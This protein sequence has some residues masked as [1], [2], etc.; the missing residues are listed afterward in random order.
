MKSKV[1]KF[2]VALISTFL[3]FGGA[4]FTACG[5]AP[6]ATISVSSSD[7]VSEDYIEID[8]GSQ[9]I[10]AEVVATVEGV[11]SGR[12]SVNN[13]NQSIIQTK[14]NYDENSNST[15]IT[16]TAV[17]EGMASFLLRS[18]EGNG[19]KLINVYVYS[20]ILD[21]QQKQDEQGYSNQYVVKG[22][23]TK[24]DAD[25][26]LTFTSRPGGESNRKDVN[27]KL[28]TQDES[29]SLNGDVLSVS[30]DSS[31]TQVKLQATSVYKPEIYEEITLAVISP[32]PEV[33]L[34]FSRN[35]DSFSEP[36]E[37]GA[38]YNL[39]KNDDSQL[40]AVAYIKLNVDV[41]TGGEL[42]SLQINASVTGAD[43]NQSDRI[44]VTEFNRMVS[45]SSTQI[46]YQIKALANDKNLQPELLQVSF[47]AKYK[48]F[49]Y[50]KSSVEFNVNLVDVIDRIEVTSIGQT[51]TSGDVVDIYDNYN[52]DS[53][54]QFGRPFVIS[55]GPDTVTNENALFDIEFNATGINVADYIRIFDERGAEITIQREGDKWVAKSIANNS[56]IYIRTSENF[57]AETQI[58]CKF[59]SQQSP[60][61]NVE[62]G[63]VCHKS[64]N[65]NFSI[66][67]QQV[68]YLSTYGENT[69]LVNVTAPALVGI[70]KGLSLRYVEN[71]VFEISDFTF[72]SAA[73]NIS[74]YVSNLTENLSGASLS[75]AVVH[76][77]GFRASEDIVIETFVPMK[78][79]AVLHQGQS[80]SSISQVEYVF[81]E[82][83]ELDA[84]NSLNSLIMKYGSSV[85]LSFNSNSYSSISVGFRYDENASA[86]FITQENMQ[87]IL[88]KFSNAETDQ[89]RYVT[90]DYASN[91]LT[92]ASA[93]FKGYV[94][95]TFKGYNDLHGEIAAYRIFYLE[96]YTS[97]SRLA[98]NPTNLSLTA[99]DSIS[100]EEKY[101]SEASVSISYRAD[102]RE[103]TYA[104]VNS[105]KFRSIATNMD[106]VGQTFVNFG[107]YEIENILITNK[108]ISFDVSAKTTQGYQSYSDQIEISYEI[109]G[110]IYYATIDIYIENAERVEVVD[111]EN[112]TSDE[113]IYL[114]LFSKETTDR[115]FPILT[116][117]LPNDAHNKD[118][119][120]TFFA[121]AGTDVDLVK[122]NQLGVVSIKTNASKGGTGFI[123]VY[124][125]DSIRIYD[126]IEQ[127]VYY[128]E[129]GNGE[130]QH[131]TPL[132]Q[133]NNYYDQIASGYYYKKD[134][135]TQTKI[136]Y[137]DIIKKIEVV[138]ADGLSETTAIR[139][140]NENQLKA[141]EFNRHYTLMNS[142]ELSSWSSLHQ[143]GFTGSL[144]GA[145]ANVV[146]SN[147]T[148]PLFKN[149]A[150]EGKVS[151]LTLIGQ[152]TGGGMVADENAGEISN[153]TIMVDS[154]QSI[155]PSSV[156]GGIIRDEQTYLGGAVGYNTGKIINVN[157]EGVT[158][159]NSTN[160]YVGGIVG[161][162]S[163]TISNSKFEFYIFGTE[164]ST[165]T[166]T[167]SG[168]FA[169]GIVGYANGGTIQNTYAYNYN[170]KNTTEDNVPIK[171]STAGN[172]N[173]GA[174]V[175]YAGSKF[176]VT[177]S[178][179]MI[180][181][182]KTDDTVQGLKAY[183]N[184]TEI[185]A[186]LTDVYWGHGTNYQSNTSSNWINPGEEGFL[187]YVRGGEAH[188]KTL[189]QSASVSDLGEFQIANTEK[190][191]YIGDKQGVLYIHKLKDS[192]SLSDSELAELKDLNTISL[193]DLFGTNGANVVA[194][195]DNALV[196][197]V[198]GNTIVLNDIGEFNLTISSKQNYTISET[199][200]IKVL[201]V[202]ADFTIWHNN[203]QTSGFNVQER[204]SADVSFTVRSS[205][206]LRGQA[207]ALQLHAMQINMTLVDEGLNDQVELSTNGMQGQIFVKEGTKEAVSP[208]ANFKV[209]AD[210]KLNNA[211]TSFENFDYDKA[212]KDATSKT[213]SITPVLGANDIR[214]SASSLTVV[215]S[216]NSQLTVILSTDD[217]DDGLKLRIEKGSSGSLTETV[218]GDMHTYSFA[219]QDVLQVLVS[220]SNY[221]SADAY[222]TYTLTIS[223]AEN[224]RS[225]IMD[226]EKY[227]LFI[228]S[229]SGT[230]DKENS[231]VELILTSQPINHIDI[232]NYKPGTT[233]STNGVN[234]YQR[235]DEATSVISPGRSSIMNIYID[236][237]FAYYEY[238]TLT[239]QN[240][241]GA[242]LGITK[243]NSYD[244][245]NKQYTVDNSSDV[246]Q[247]DYGVRAGRESDGFFA[248]RLNAAGNI[249]DDTKFVLTVQFYDKNGDPIEDAMSTYELF[250][251]YLPEA[252]ITIDGEVSAV[253]A[254]GGNLQLKMLLKSDQ[255]LDSV[256]ALN[257]SGIT[258][259]APSAWSVQDNGNGT[260]TLTAALYAN[261]DA[262]IISD[263]GPINGEF[264]L[265]AQVSRV[266]NGITEIKRSYAYITI[267]DFKPATASVYGAKYDDT[268]QMQVVDANIGISK[269]VSFEYQFDPETYSYDHS[270]GDEITLVENLTKARKQFESDKYYGEATD[271]FTI[272]LDSDGKPIPVYQRLYIGDQKLNFSETS[273]GSKVWTWS[274][275]NFRLTYREESN[276]LSVLGLITTSVTNPTIITLRD[277][278]R[279][280]SISGQNVVYPIET[281]FA[282]QVTVFSDVDMPI[283]IE[284]ENDFLQV[285]QE[286]TAQNYILMDDIVLQNY[287]PISAANFKSLDGNGHTIHIQSFNTT[288][289][290]TLNLALF[291]DIPAESIMK[292][293]KVNYYNGGNLT[294]DTTSAGYQNINVAGFA[295]SNSGTITNCQVIAYQNDG[296]TVQNGEVG[297]IVNLVRG[298][299]PYYIGDTSITSNVAGFVLNNSG[300]ITN[301]KVGGDQIIVIGENIRDN[302][303]TYTNTQ[304]QNF[305]ISAQGE[306]A[307]FVLSNSGEIASSGAQNIQITNKASLSSS[308]TAGF[309]VSNSGEIR[310]SYVEGVRQN[311]EE[312]DA[313]LYH[314]QGSNISSKGIVAGF[315]VNNGINGVV[316]DGYSNILI[317]NDTEIKSRTSAGFVYKNEGLVQYS[318]SASFVEKADIL[319]LNFSGVD[320]NG[321]NLNSGKIELSYYINENYDQDDSSDVQERISNQATLVVIG[322]ASKE[323]AFY[324][325]TF[326]SSDSSEDGVWRRTDEGPR[327]VSEDTVTVSHRYYVAIAADEYSLPYAILQNELDSSAPKYDTA[328]GST[329]NP[330]LI[331]NANDFKQAM[332]DSTS[333]SIGSYFSDSEVF[334]AYRFTSDI[335]LSQLN[336]EHGEAEV[337]SIDKLFSGTIDG[338][339]FAINN[340]SIRSSNNSVGLFSQADRAVI[341]N[342]DLL[343][344]NVTASNSY[345]VGG[346]VGFVEDSIIFNVHMTQKT[347]DTSSTGIGVLGR[348]IAG[349]I[350]GAAFGDTKLNNLTVEDAI[351]QASYYDETQNASDRNMLYRAGFDPNSIRTSQRQN[352]NNFFSNN[353]ATGGVGQVSFAGGVV[354]YLDVYN[355]LEASYTSF[356]Y[357]S[358]I[359]GSSYPVKKLSA[360]GVID[361]RGEV[362]GGVFGFT[363]Y[364]TK[365][366]DVSTK[367][368]T[369]EESVASILSYNYFAGGVVGLANGQFYQIYSEHEESV[370]DEIENTTANYYLAGS[371]ETQ[372]GALDLFKF[373]GAQASGEYRYNPKY[374][375]G[376]MGVIGSGSIYVGYNK[377]N[378]I[379]YTTENSFAGGIAGGVVAGSN[380]YIETSDV[381]Q[382][383]IATTLFLQ[384]VY[385]IGDVY[386]YGTTFDEKGN[387]VQS[388]TSAFGG[389]F[390]SLKQNSKLLLSSV[391]AFN[392]YGVLDNPYYAQT[393]ENTSGATIYAIAGDVANDAAVAVTISSTAKTNAANESEGETDTTSVKSFGYMSSYKSGDIS[394]NV[395]PLPEGVE[396]RSD[397]IFVIRSVSSFSSQS[398]GYGETNGAFI[399]SKAWSSENWT[400]ALNTLYPE[401]NFINSVNYIYL[402]QYNVDLV[403]EKM[404]NSSIEVRVRGKVSPDANNDEYGMVDL[405]GKE[406]PIEG[407][408]GTIVGATSNEWFDGNANAQKA[409]NAYKRADGTTDSGYPGL[410]L[411]Q[412][413][414]SNPGTGLRVSN[415]NVVIASKAQGDTYPTTDT[416][417]KVTLTGGM[418]SNGT[419]N[420]AKIQGVKVYVQAPV[421]VA[422]SADS[423]GLLAPSASSTSFTNIE[424]NFN[425]VATAS[426]VPYITMGGSSEPNTNAA[427][428]DAE[429]DSKGVAN[430]GLLV[431][432][433]TQNSI[434]EAIRIQNIDIKH[435][436]LNDSY[437]MKA[438]VTGNAHVGL[439]V[440][441][442]TEPENSGSEQN[443]PQN[444]AGVM[445]RLRAP[446]G[447][448]DHK[449][450]DP[451]TTT[452]EV[453]NNNAIAS[454]DY[455]GYFGL[456][457]SQN[458]QVELE[459]D[460]GYTQTIKMVTSTGVTGYANIG[461]LI[462][463]ANLQDFVVNDYRTNASANNIAGIVS[464]EMVFNANGTRTINGGNVGLLFGS[465]DGSFDIEDLGASGIIQTTT[466]TGTGTGTNST[467]T[468]NGSNFGG[469]IGANKSN[470]KISNVDVALSAYKDKEANISAKGFDVDTEN[471]ILVADTFN[472]GGFIGS[473]AAPVTVEKPATGGNNT[474]NNS[475]ANKIAFNASSA[476]VNAGDLIGYNVGSITASMFNS[477]SLISINDAQ[478]ANVGGLIGENLSTATKFTS[479]NSAI[480]I[481]VTSNFFINSTNL[482]AGGMI[483]NQ[484]K[485][486]SSGHS[487]EYVV[488][489][490]AFKVSVDEKSTGT[491]TVG[492]MIGKIDDESKDS[493]FE[494]S[495][496]KN[497]GDAIYSYSGD[498]DTASQIAQY[499]FGGL[500]GSARVVEKEEKP[501]VNVSGNVIAFTN[502]NPRLASS[503]S[504][505]S[506]LIGNGGSATFGENNYYSSQLVLATSDEKKMID[507][508]YNTPTNQGYGETAATNADTILSKLGSSLTNNVEVGSKLKPISETENNGDG[509]TNGITYYAGIYP[510][511]ESSGT[512]QTQANEQSNAFAY[513]GDFVKSERAI[514][515][516]GKHSFVAGLV[517]ENNYP[518]EGAGSSNIDDIQNV[519]GV[520]DVLNGGIVYASMATG[521]LSVGGTALKNVGGLV[522][523]MNGGL[524]AESTSSVNIVYRAKQDGTASAVATTSTGFS[525]FDKVYSTGEVASYISA[526]LYAFTNGE[527]A[528]VRDSYTIS[529]VNLKDYTA[530]TVSGTTGVFGGASAYNNNVK[531]SNNWYDADATEV[532]ESGGAAIQYTNSTASNNTNKSTDK[533]LAYGDTSTSSTPI[534]G[535]KQDI[536]YNYGYPTRNFA[537]F[538]VSTTET[539]DGKTYHLIPNATKLSQIKDG[540]GLNYKLVRDIDLS[541]TSFTANDTSWNKV[542]NEAIF[543]GDGHTI[544]GVKA[545]LFSSA[546]T[547]KNLRV[548]NAV[549]TGNAVVASTLTGLAENVT[550][551]GTLTGKASEDDKL[552]AIGGLFASAGNTTTISNC[553]NYV[554]VDDDKKGRNIGGIVGYTGGVITNCYNYSPI[555]VNS[556]GSYVGGI[557]GSATRI[558]NS[559]NENT[560][561]NGYTEGGNGK[562]Y[563]GGIAGMTTPGGTVQNCYN[564]AMVKAGNKGINAEGGNDKIAYAAGIVASA[565]T[566][567]TVTGC[568]NEG[569]IEALGSTKEASIQAEKAKGETG[570]A[571]DAETIDSFASR[572][573]QYNN[574]GI[575]NEGIT[576]VQARAIVGNAVANSDTENEN[577]HTN[578]GTIFQNGLFGRAR[579]GSMQ[580]TELANFTGTDISGGID[581]THTNTEVVA[582]TDSLGGPLSIYLKS[583][584]TLTYGD[585]VSKTQTAYTE[586][587]EFGTNT[588]N[589]AENKTYE[590]RALTLEG[591]YGAATID[592]A[593]SGSEDENT[594]KYV[595][596][597]GK[598]YAFVDDGEGLTAALNKGYQIFTVTYEGTVG[599]AEIKKLFNEGYKFEASITSGGEGSASTKVVTKEDGTFAL[600][601]TF[602]IKNQ[603][604]ATTQASEQT[605]NY[606]ITAKKG[607][608]SLKVFLSA[609][610]LL[611]VN[612]KVQIELLY[613]VNSGQTFEFPVKTNGA[614]GEETIYYVFQ[615]TASEGGKTSTLQFDKAYKFALN[616]KGEQTQVELS[617]NN[618][619][620]IKALN[621][622]QIE[623]NINAG[624]YS[625]DGLTAYVSYTADD[626]TKT[627]IDGYIAVYDEDAGDYTVNSF[628]RSYART[629]Q[630]GTVTTTIEALKIGEE[631]SLTQP[632]TLREE[633]TVSR[634]TGT[635]TN[636]ET[637]ET[638]TETVKGTVT[639]KISALGKLSKIS[640]YETAETINLLKICRISISEEDNHPYSFTSGTS[641]KWKLCD[642]KA[643]ASTVF[644]TVVYGDFLG[645]VWISEADYDE[646]KNVTTYTIEVVSNYT[647][648]EYNNYSTF[649]TDVVNTLGF[650]HEYAAGEGIKSEEADA[651]F[652]P[653]FEDETIVKTQTLSNGVEATLT[654]QKFGDPVAVEGGGN[655]KHGEYLLQTG[656]QIRS[657]NQHYVQ[658]YKLVSVS[659]ETSADNVKIYNNGWVDFNT[660]DGGTN[661]VN[662]CSQLTIN[663]TQYTY[664]INQYN[665]MIL[666]TVGTD[667]TT[668]SYV[669]EKATTTEDGY[670]STI[671]IG[672]NTYNFTFNANKELITF[673]GGTIS[674]KQTTV[675]MLTFNAQKVISSTSEIKYSTI[676]QVKKPVITVQEGQL[677][678]TEM[679]EDGFKV[680][681]SQVTLDGATYTV[682]VAADNTVT[683][684]TDGES[685][686]YE[687]YEAILINGKYYRIIDTIE[688]AEAGEDTGGEVVE[689]I[690][691]DD[692]VFVRAIVGS[693]GQIQVD[694]VNYTYYFNYSEGETGEGHVAH[695]YGLDNSGGVLNEDTGD[696]IYTIGGKSYYGYT[697]IVDI[698]EEERPDAV[699]EWA[700]I[701]DENGNSIGT[702]YTIKMK[703]GK[704]F[705]PYYVFDVIF[706]LDEEAAK[707]EVT[708]SNV[709]QTVTLPEFVDTV[710]IKDASGQPYDEKA[711]TL[712]EKSEE[713]SNGRIVFKPVSSNK[714][715][716]ITYTFEDFTATGQAKYTAGGG[717]DEPFVGIVLTNDVDLGVIDEATGYENQFSFAGDGHMVQFYSSARNSLL[718]GK[719]DRFIKDVAFAGTIFRTSGSG[720]TALISTDF[721]GAL[722]NVQTYGTLGFGNGAVETTAGGTRANFTASL[723]VKSAGAVTNFSNYASYSYFTNKYN[724]ASN[725]VSV[726]VFG[727]IKGLAGDFKNYGTLIGGNGARGDDVVKDGVKGQDVSLISSISSQNVDSANIYNHGIVKAGDGGNGRRGADGRGGTDKTDGTAPTNGTK[728]SAGGNK[729]A[730]GEAYYYGDVYTAT[731][732]DKHTISGTL[733]NGTA[734]TAGSQGNDG[735]GGLNLTCYYATRTKKAYFPGK[736]R[737]SAALS[738]YPYGKSSENKSVDIPQQFQSIDDGIVNSRFY[739]KVH[740]GKGYTDSYYDHSVDGLQHMR[741]GGPRYE[742]NPNVGNSYYFWLY[743]IYDG[744]PKS[745][746]GDEKVHSFTSDD[747]NFSIYFK[748]SGNYG[749]KNG[750]GGQYR[751]NDFQIRVWSAPIDEF[752]SAVC[753][754]PEIEIIQ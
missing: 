159:G 207:Y 570:A 368:A 527:K 261:L 210:V 445:I 584:R 300:S 495:N 675:S 435:P 732:T 341:K 5:E 719:S 494:I 298:S 451:F 143:N 280:K 637:G 586:V 480:D 559:G 360:Q 283:L 424:I 444:Y 443:E 136:Y 309:A 105:V 468:F 366:Q 422:A 717:N 379:N 149:I 406:R 577:N 684:T 111:W 415:L 447:Y 499:Y 129:K 555:N 396:L 99:L 42:P 602:V 672:E 714:D 369:D 399:N 15:K 155:Q 279:V 230:T 502:N 652:K 390:G 218:A 650:N 434:F 8:I 525:Y 125:K 601:I 384:E 535:W 450:D 628:K 160:G 571:D 457:N 272:N 30:G 245:D 74:F 92:L 613:R 305:V 77:N 233:F 313:K 188:L 212:I 397:F 358:D 728:G 306:V 546:A 616:E 745:F 206:Y 338:N 130:E 312:E 115:T 386:S 654:Y 214:I 268:L 748:I 573:L 377:L 150:S 68:R 512:T 330:I 335:D 46:I 532:A 295:I 636:P 66:G 47:G 10:V 417:K 349:G 69:L 606:T 506:A 599:G 259:S 709:S 297:L 632:I 325:F 639:Y 504:Q 292:N 673:D 588:E 597:A 172:E 86:E 646:E 165:Y 392:H 516:V 48:N 556:A 350:I 727:D 649:I 631:P 725:S 648:F 440:G 477:S 553:K 704:A 449:N 87:E 592:R 677:V 91:R 264:Q 688:D 126:G 441:L 215:P 234:V 458:A 524:I 665:R 343:I 621:G 36:V 715:L 721:D 376:L 26:F 7:F 615:S 407:F 402:D 320:K 65:A 226:D 162:N 128:V 491:H 315:V 536:K 659:I 410:I 651:N 140:Y 701:T 246:E 109:F 60:S 108:L 194:S 237:D 73:G 740:A 741:A 670:S 554:K 754:G 521:T 228:S 270:N 238:M 365:V 479:R 627:N 473:N 600:E 466:G 567:A 193:T 106:A 510:T 251:S 122:I 517:V 433:L 40:E 713:E 544:N 749:Y 393:K 236:P 37:Q 580:F 610:N 52:G 114:D 437:L 612:N 44:S 487:I 263:N 618:A 508:G 574:G 192:S 63:L 62:I 723:A 252:E 190:S 282:V 614:D 572:I 296:A 666:L 346:L 84:A 32:L 565:G 347:D 432:T 281:R 729:G 375:G 289:S 28:L 49:S 13:D 696:R 225:S 412:A 383:R 167:I 75:I 620:I 552:K 438:N 144:I 151:S 469:L 676:S 476:T 700:N 428:E 303:V 241:D 227:T 286:G 154:E 317:K 705:K 304:L 158:V 374:V 531:N 340:I 11:S 593:Q 204:T 220:Q 485:V 687:M 380:Y 354:G 507:I 202:V 29:V 557:A 411:D 427:K 363:G 367:I 196:A 288:G 526:K 420:D 307:G 299:T 743:A 594:T 262:G 456:V 699:L 24:L 686:T 174:F 243:L 94:L 603:E 462:G 249:S 373:K 739:I 101:L 481:R 630:S 277:E 585:S 78:N 222:Y 72:D 260:K 488:F 181:A 382:P 141:I 250:V 216:Y 583:V 352:I 455:G 662:N 57:V 403:I 736:N 645:E 746:N 529:K 587:K 146:I 753:R 12:V 633:S 513:I 663:N 503:K 566:G 254:K 93:D 708:L 169:G 70:N 372:R 685:T 59:I 598:Q 404:Q 604:Q 493:L 334:G 41:P 195:V 448:E 421:V 1:S 474:F 205:I 152:A 157:V 683:L 381:S 217:T 644:D 327:L 575:N 569:F 64:P 176:T 362:V 425:K 339:G 718:T 4:F 76:E 56:L 45:D 345:V 168:A 530:E 224:Y 475:G 626:I 81:Q 290:G 232:S 185:A 318:Y 752:L 124:P 67:A 357:N 219:G 22:E 401:I 439:Y 97:P 624:E 247:V 472:F 123:Y 638:T 591:T 596:I 276:S 265:E 509:D 387:I 361:I 461:G 737:W 9:D 582:E 82:F 51:I 470:L 39:V 629:S 308:Q 681:N 321:N 550:A 71:Q 53:T 712:Y 735:W 278:M 698:A 137:K 348:N 634:E 388:S 132:S 294:I 240:S 558:S 38:S 323:N 589:D 608:Q 291:N 3:L 266:M 418:L 336:N 127:F 751:F 96:S 85:N 337:K 678:L 697:N 429:G 235:T 442:L 231:P 35:Y 356:V 221:N 131:A 564:T 186:T 55:L 655:T 371:S 273:T 702:S 83:G 568:I 413:L 310:Y 533:T 332:G 707:N 537:A 492:G 611:E 113:V 667:G 623:I 706:Y 619:D 430:A 398:E 446:Q 541:K 653:T 21:L 551:S 523:I 198:V 539:A 359:Q 563:A 522:G 255:E 711:Y 23:D 153:I 658:I 170:L 161:Y 178:F 545:T 400:H 89:D 121:N 640:N 501:T 657:Q 394:I 482:N 342:L 489:G 213:L 187:E 453:A 542:S 534:A 328:Y 200:Q 275:S 408:S 419:L 79:A 625:Q 483:G 257:T 744:G 103:I 119:A 98:P 496:T 465:A 102:G 515:T 471:A 326:T 500:V 139:I 19:Q 285:A 197:Q 581:I 414:L 134:G 710:E 617:L 331:T 690:L 104:D 18:H 505:S 142:I 720:A 116:N 694:G 20:D 391:N 750:T 679:E 703:D 463:D 661:F 324:G 622:L 378:A 547:L 148:Q 467:F 478:K 184:T 668:T 88:N 166:N 316:S 208:N 163:G 54:Y 635:V 95:V 183:S 256:V 311:V 364:Q 497:Y 731:Q 514:S 669:S 423:A 389:L 351:V 203:I 642:F 370:Q 518:D 734:G 693:K 511:F 61:V 454:L 647:N 730:Q 329:L 716:T 355:T 145:N 27:W 656:A 173:V 405:R 2:F 738:I 258:I 133:L 431:G 726:N 436:D 664:F 562:Y 452:I 302:I 682:A 486:S 182:T 293:I 253:I 179:S 135:L 641:E 674:A 107:N 416:E 6:K 180:Y 211:A 560:V 747:K 267:V 498:N 660:T 595:S 284:N 244:S 724:S 90:F 395:A 319:Q 609:S 691:P 426:S 199:F 171:G 191:L 742:T 201:Y 576:N 229:I 643:H 120:Y 14:A 520:V 17:S 353:L 223:V 156:T 31:L 164:S 579:F 239:Y 528:T 100:E 248:F 274:N 50:V 209:V 344:D 287:T 25:R 590:Q 322:E 147:L 733:T 242:V 549:V 43:G 33:Q 175:G 722:N 34:L 689:E 561:F 138:V 385:T 692:L 695:I 301:S 538:N 484:G 543:D 607:S 16:I 271:N 58:G 460:E 314:I 578:H 409:Y 605:I 548:T 490:G 269:D 671:T 118:V 110:T 333:T 459:K 680:E 189:Y 117:V 519:G 177:N 464:S 112:M 540:T 80:S